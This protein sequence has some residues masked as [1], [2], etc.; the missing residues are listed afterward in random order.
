MQSECLCSFLG[1]LFWNEKFDIE[2][3]I[4]IINTSTSQFEELLHWNWGSLCANFIGDKST[5]Y[6]IAGLNLLMK[7][8]I[9]YMFDCNVFWLLYSDEFQPLAHIYRIRHNIM[10]FYYVF[11]AR[12]TFYVNRAHS[13]LNFHAR[14]DSGIFQVLVWPNQ[15]FVFVVKITHFP[16]RTTN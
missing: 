8:V 10:E 4:E 5:T 12:S 2:I 13:F 3:I 15:Y 11:V 16:P 7:I 6:I 1:L 9:G 14:Y